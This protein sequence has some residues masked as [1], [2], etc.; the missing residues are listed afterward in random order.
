MVS[1]SKARTWID[2]MITCCAAAFGIEGVANHVLNCAAS[3]PNRRLPDR[4]SAAIL[5]WAAFGRLDEELIW[6]IVS[7]NFP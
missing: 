3:S 2:E 1:Q 4:W 7:I 5:P 6:T